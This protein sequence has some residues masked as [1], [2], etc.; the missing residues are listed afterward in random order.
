MSSSAMI[1]GCKQKHRASMRNKER[2]QD[3]D[4]DHSKAYQLTDRF[5][6][7]KSLRHMIIRTNSLNWML[8]SRFTLGDILPCSKIC[9]LM[10]I[11]IQKWRIQDSI[12]EAQFEDCLIPVKLPS[13]AD[14]GGYFYLLLPLWS[15]HSAHKENRHYSAPQTDTA[16]IQEENIQ[17]CRQGF[18]TFFS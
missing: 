16:H 5:N 6:S 1:N 4:P 11:K 18:R 14:L 9:H 3:K 13:T 7:R 12:P 8:L 2:G 10:N 17:G 15:P